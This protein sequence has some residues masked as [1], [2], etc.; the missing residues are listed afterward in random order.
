MK[1][2]EAEN[3]LEYSSAYS[4]GWNQAVEDFNDGIA[5][6]KAKNL[7]LKGELRERYIEGYL[8]SQDELLI[9]RAKAREAMQDAGIY[10]T[11][12]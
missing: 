2:T 5:D 8:A 9:N 1:I 10:I 6:S 7:H 4:L 11:R 3:E 12:G